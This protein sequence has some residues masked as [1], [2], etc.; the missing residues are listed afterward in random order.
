MGRPSKGKDARSIP[1][2]VR[3][4]ER[5]KRDWTVKARTA[6]QPL[7]AW[8]AQPRRDEEAEQ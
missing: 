2:M 8:I 3:I 5:E 7:S 4:S 6:D 1:I